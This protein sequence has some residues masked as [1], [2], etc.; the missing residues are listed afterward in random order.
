MIN[1]T[2]WWRVCPDC[3]KT[4]FFPDGLKGAVTKSLEERGVK[5]PEKDTWQAVKEIEEC[6]VD[7]AMSG[8][9]DQK[10]FEFDL[11]GFKFGFWATEVEFFL[12][13]LKKLELRDEI[14]VSYYK[15]HG[16]HHCACLR[17]EDREL[18]IRRMEQKLD[19]ANAIR[20][21]ENREFNDRIK[22][23]PSPHCISK[24]EVGAVEES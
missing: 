16:A 18:L 3:T 9:V 12:R 22:D 19:E 13:R 10:W 11:Q 5:M 23:I 2:K 17:P 1:K 15:L 20:E 21:V 14:G 4:H 6:G 8:P 24:R 7:L